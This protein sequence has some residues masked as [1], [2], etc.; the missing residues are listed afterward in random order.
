MSHHLMGNEKNPHQDN[1][2]TISGKYQKYLPY[3]DNA[4]SSTIASYSLVSTNSS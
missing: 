3:F 2:L 1:K 4:F